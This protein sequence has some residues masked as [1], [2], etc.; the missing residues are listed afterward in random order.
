MVLLGRYLVVLGRGLVVFGWSLVLLGGC[1]VVSLV[2]VL[3]C[4]LVVLCSCSVGYC[5]GLVLVFDWA[6]YSVAVR[7]VLYW[8]D[9]GI[10]LVFGWYCVLDCVR[11]ACFSNPASVHSLDWMV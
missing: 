4:V 7:L 6:W 11:L 8:I 2:V 1:L 5:T 3:G 10:Q 9:V